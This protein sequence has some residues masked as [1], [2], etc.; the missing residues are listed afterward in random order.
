MSEHQVSLE[1][2][3]VLY[4][5]SSTT[6]FL[7]ALLTLS[8]ILLMAS[9]AALSVYTRELVIIEM[10]AGQ[11]ICEGLNWALKRLVKQDR[12]ED[13]L[14]H[15]YGFPSSHSQNMGYFASFLMCHL[16]FRHRFATT[17]NKIL[18]KAWRLL[19]YIGLLVW[20]GIVAYSRYRLTYHT[21][22]Q[23]VWGLAIGIIYGVSFYTVTEFIPIRRPEGVFGRIRSTVLY[24][25]LS[26]WVELRDGWLVY[27]D[28]G[29]AEEWKLWRAKLKRSETVQ[30]TMQRPGEGMDRGCRKE[31]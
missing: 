5:P 6:S 7:L 2:T 23:I 1:L 12:P 15:G 16:Y 26:E 10:W 31:L 11:F 24:N 4:D 3:H 30:D 21:P 13:T 22:H 29:R 28:G 17:G 20:S 14:G 25:S 18:D 19:L 8:P 27:S 9:Y